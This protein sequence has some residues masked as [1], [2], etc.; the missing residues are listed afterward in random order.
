VLLL[1]PVG[2]QLDGILFDNFSVSDNNPAVVSVIGING[3]F[4]GGPDN[5]LRFTVSPAAPPA[6]GIDILL[7][8][9][10]SGL[11]GADIELGNYSGLPSVTETVCAVEPV[12]G[13]CPA[14]Q[15]LAR[16]AASHAGPYG[17]AYFPLT[18]P[19]WIMKDINIPFGSTMSDFANS[20]AVP[21]PVTLSLIGFGLFALGLLRRRLK[22]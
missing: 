17:E 7:G 11:L 4:S 1:N 3:A 21:E 12:M 18:S 20:H 9:R 22:K 6:G 2:C 16:I 19:V 13:I 8:Y 15:V 14:E 5:V 10:V